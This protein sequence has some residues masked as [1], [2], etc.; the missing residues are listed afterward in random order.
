MATAFFFRAVASDGKLRTGTLTAET[1]RHV[2]AEL[3][4]QGLIPVYVGLGAKERAS[5]FKLPAFTAR[6]AARTFCSSP[7]NCRRCSTPACRSTARSR[8]PRELTEH[9]DFR[10]AGAGRGPRAE[11]RQIAGRQSGDASGVLFASCTSTWCA[12]GKLPARWRRFS[13]AWRNS[14]ARATT[15]AATSSA[16]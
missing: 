2:A 6:Q 12:P 1:D 11:G 14:S 4:R 5:T 8:S 7:R 16:R 9:A 15:C 3:Q 13:S 10:T